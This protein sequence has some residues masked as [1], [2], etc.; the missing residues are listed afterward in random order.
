MSA[1]TKATDVVLTSSFESELDGVAKGVK[2]NARVPNIVAELRQ[3]LKSVPKLWSDNIA[4]VRFV[5]GEGVAKGVR[6]MEL[7]MWNVG[8]RYKQG[9]VLIDWIS[10]VT[11]PADKLTKL[12]TREEHEVFTRQIMGLDLLLELARVCVE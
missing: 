4:M 5:Q 11:I 7:C 3:K 12:A 8:E 10:G 2:G 9:S 1:H 6:H